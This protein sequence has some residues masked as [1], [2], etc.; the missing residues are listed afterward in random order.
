MFGLGDGTFSLQTREEL[1][2]CNFTAI[3]DINNDTFLD[4]S[5]SSF[6]DNTDG[7]TVYF[8]DGTG[9]AVAGTT[10]PI[11][12][13]SI[14]RLHAA[15]FDGDGNNDLVMSPVFG[16]LSLF[17]GNGR[18]GFSSRLR[19]E[20]EDANYLGYGDVLGDARPEIFRKPT[21]EGSDAKRRDGYTSW[22]RFRR[23]LWES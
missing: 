3:A 18:G 16:E 8:G 11:P 17:L 4:Y 15:D 9:N 14:C 6:I 21:N 19:F 20:R 5:V 13:S 12:G 1:G 7:F 23:L 22:K 2:W 10:I